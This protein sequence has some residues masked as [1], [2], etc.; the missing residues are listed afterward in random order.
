LSGVSRA[1]ARETPDNSQNYAPIAQVVRSGLVESVHFGAAVILDGDG[2]LLW[3]VGDPDV[4]IYPRSANKPMQAAGMVRN[5]L[6]VTPQQLAL[7]AASHSGEPFHVDEVRAI[8][9][10]YGL[11][12]PAL[13]NTPDLPMDEAAQ[14]GVLRHGEGRRSITADC[15]GK[16][17]GMVATCV[18][19]DWDTVSYCDFDHP[20]QRRLRDE[21]AQWAGEPVR[22]A[23]V[24]GCGAPAWAISLRGLAWA[25]SGVVTAPPDDPARQVADAMRAHPQFVGGTTRDVT[26]FMRAV[27]GLLA[28]EGAEGVYAAAL[29]DGRAVAVKASDGGRRAAQV[30]LADALAHLGVPSD[31]LAELATVPVLGHGRPVGEC[32]V[33]RASTP[34]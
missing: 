14:W 17:A 25:F 2:T 33:L 16:H 20:L 21:L 23:G 18:V 7:V 4:V 30:T 19:N 1:Y 11:G 3:S 9:A 8:L 32:R 12:E 24:D 31:A 22:H 13:Q 15:S 29:P 6:D 5:G 28:K 27:P 26:A 34:L 10:R